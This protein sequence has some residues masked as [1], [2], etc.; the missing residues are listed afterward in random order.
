MTIA[1]LRQK[2]REELTTVLA[3]ERERLAELRFLLAQ[4]KVKNVKEVVAIRKDVARI[5]T[6][7]QAL[8]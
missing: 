6:V 4:K 1:E 2:S 7:L 5:L 8:S 3:E